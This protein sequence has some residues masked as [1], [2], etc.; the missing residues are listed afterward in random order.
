MPAIPVSAPAGTVPDDTGSFS[1]RRVVST[2]RRPRPTNRVPAP[3]TSA[4]AATPP[5]LSR[6]RRRDS[7]TDGRGRAEVVRK[8][9]STVQTM[10]PTAS[11]S[12]EYGVKSGRVIA[13]T[14][15]TAAIAQK[16]RWP[17]TLRRAV[18]SPATAPS[19]RIAIVTPA[20]RKGLSLRPTRWISLSA[21]GPGVLAM[22]TS[23]TTCTGV[24]RAL[25]NRVATSAATTPARA[26]DAPARASRPRE[27]A[28]TSLCSPLGPTRMA[29][30]AR[31]RR[32]A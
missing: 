32:T 22:T 14:S 11:G 21:T 28:S 8:S 29:R 10:T 1:S 16:T 18:S 9:S 17:K 15:A 24:A 12:S 3:T 26:A 5:A 23:A 6:N 13:A 4:A 31:P 27:A 19:P 7:S 25:S 30:T 2:A 20:T